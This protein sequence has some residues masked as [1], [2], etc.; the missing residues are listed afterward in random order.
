MKILQKSSAG[1]IEI[2]SDNCGGESRSPVTCTHIAAPGSPRPSDSP[3]SAPTNAPLD[4]KSAAVNRASMLSRMRNARSSSNIMSSSAPQLDRKWE[5]LSC[6]FLYCDMCCIAVSKVG[7]AV[8]GTRAGS[9]YVWDVSTKKV[10]ARG[11]GSNPSLRCI[12]ATCVVH[13]S[14]W[15]PRVVGTCWSG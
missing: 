11:L 2:M 12:N 10:R 8:A 1:F 7:L 6:K 4:E 9:V 3:Q 14:N 15:I 5:H 13:L